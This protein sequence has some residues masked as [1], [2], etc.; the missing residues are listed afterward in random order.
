MIVPIQLTTARGNSRAFLNTQESSLAKLPLDLIL[1]ILKLLKLNDIKAVSMTCRGF[2]ALSQDRDLWLFLYQRAFLNTPAPQVSCYQSFKKLCSNL[3]NGVYT[4]QH[5]RGT[6]CL[7]VNGMVIYGFGDGRIGQW[8][9]GTFQGHTASVTS[10]LW[11][12]GMLISGSADNTI[13]VWDFTYQQCLKTLTLEEKSE[14]VT[15][16]LWNGKHL[17]SG[18]G[19]GT[20]Q[21]WDLKTGT[22]V[23]TLRGHQR[24]ISSLL[25]VDGNLV[26]SSLDNTIKIWDLYSDSPKNVNFDRAK[27]PGSNCFSEG[28]IY[29][30]LPSEKQLNRGSFRVGQNSHFLASRS[31]DQ[32]LC[33]KTMKD[34][35]SVTSLIWTNERLI[36]ATPQTVSCWDIN[37]GE[38]ESLPITARSIL[39]VGDLLFCGGTSLQVWDLERRKLLWES[40]ALFN[41][42]ALRWGEGKLFF[43]VSDGAYLYDFNASNEAVFKEIAKQFKYKEKPDDPLLSFFGYKEPY[44]FD[45]SIP[46][47]RFSRMPRKDRE[48]IQASVW[49][50]KKSDE[51]TDFIREWRARAIKRHLSRPSRSIPIHNRSIAPVITVMVVSLL[52][53]KGLSWLMGESSNHEFSSL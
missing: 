30:I 5:N 7:C 15:A 29:S 34:S 10:L 41:V 1:R 52:I 46:M 49:F 6:C 18:S 19:N 2:N 4:S 25:N 33:V 3:A 13:K 43:S 36:S 16:L 11:I 40:E 38:R 53:L 24:R 50:E 28:C 42:H 44:K 47:D 51:T 8:G 37:S 31:I 32:N 9:N 48:Q 20:I 21:M 22:C 35:G 12:D 26:S 14:G 45:I 39:W 23:E 17:I 27:A